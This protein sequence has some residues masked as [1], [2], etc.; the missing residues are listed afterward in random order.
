VVSPDDAG[1]C[2]LIAVAAPPPSTKHLSTKPLNIA[3]HR[4][5]SAS[6][7]MNKQA[8]LGCSSLK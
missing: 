1:F 4:I 3:M 7:H 2:D 8:F 5:T 6:H